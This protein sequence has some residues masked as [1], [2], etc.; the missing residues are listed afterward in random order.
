MDI[1]EKEM[2][3]EEKERKQ[4]SMLMDQKVANINRKREEDERREIERKKLIGKE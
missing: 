1:T 4:R 2:S 3:D